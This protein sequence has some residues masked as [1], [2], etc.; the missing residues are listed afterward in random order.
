MVSAFFVL[1]RFEV[2]NSCLLIS[3]DVIRHNICI[4]NAQYSS[5]SAQGNPWCENFEF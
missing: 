1:T 2:I 3:N 5:F 4:S